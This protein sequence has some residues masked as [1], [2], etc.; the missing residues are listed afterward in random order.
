MVEGYKI[1]SKKTCLKN[2]LERYGIKMQRKKLESDKADRLLNVEITSGNPRKIP[3]SLAT[4]EALAF[5]QNS[6]AL[7]RTEFA[8][9]RT[10]LAL[11]NS[12]LAADRTHLS[13]LRTI[14][15]LIGSGA[16]L[17]ETLPLLGVNVTFT[18]ILSGFL[19]LAALYFIYK[20]ATTYPRLK[21]RL[22][23]LEEHA[24][25][26]AKETEDQVYR[27]E[28]DLPDEDAP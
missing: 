28:P 10:D 23:A 13:Y 7:E 22:V 2:R 15:S 6:L 19:F 14:V 9:I 26:L 4:D 16:A 12:R 21:R 24:N 20:D 1:D 25:R 5:N 18:A 3:N 17:H 8:K 27:F 11:T